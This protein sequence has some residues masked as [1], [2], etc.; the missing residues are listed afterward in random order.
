MNTTHKSVLGQA[1]GSEDKITQFKNWLSHVLLVILIFI[2]FYCLFTSTLLTHVKCT[3]RSPK[4]RIDRA[5]FSQ[6]RIIQEFDH[7]EF[8]VRK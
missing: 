4:S 8:S 2:V 7:E 5:V 1:Q 3:Y 6:E